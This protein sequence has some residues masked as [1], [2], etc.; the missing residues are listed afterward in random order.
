MRHH[1]TR[2]RPEIF[3]VVHA[4]LCEQHDESFL[5]YGELIPS[6]E[7]D[8]FIEL[9]HV[10]IK[11]PSTNFDVKKGVFHALSQVWDFQA[12]LAGWH[13]NDGVQTIRPRAHARRIVTAQFDDGWGWTDPGVFVK[14]EHL[15][16]ASEQRC[17]EAVE[18]IT[19]TLLDSIESTV[20]YWNESKIREDLLNFL[21]GL[22]DNVRALNRYLTRQQHQ[23]F[24]Y[25]LL[26]IAPIAAIFL[27]G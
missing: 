14:L 1:S 12:R 8:L 2:L 11:L 19:D 25:F 7:M 17:V 27:M 13:T 22:F 26:L 20:D 23:L 4:I 24:G 18:R 5:K 21:W 6:W 3:R 9:C 16:Y 10:T 15:I